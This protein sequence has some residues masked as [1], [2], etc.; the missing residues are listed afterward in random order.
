VQ[1][2]ILVCVLALA[3]WRSLEQWMQGRAWV[4]TR[5]NCSRKWRRSKRGRDRAGAMRR[6]AHRTATARHF[7][8]R[9]APE[10]AT[11]QLLAHLGLRLP[12]APSNRSR[13]S[14]ENRP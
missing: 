11:V 7:H 5:A 13:Y 9:T 12:K 14:A 6:G 3:L 4:P 2:Q 10:P 8:A 1:A